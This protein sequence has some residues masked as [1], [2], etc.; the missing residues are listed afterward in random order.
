M[1]GSGTRRG[2][3]L[4]GVG[5]GDATRFCVTTINRKKRVFF[6]RKYASSTAPDSVT[7]ISLK[8]RVVTITL[9]KRLCSH[10]L[11]SLSNAR[12]HTVIDIMN[13]LSNELPS[14]WNWQFICLS[15]PFRP[16]ANELPASSPHP[17]PHLQ[18]GNSITSSLAIHNISHR[19]YK[20]LAMR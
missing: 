11:D 1:S 5:V 12:E 15:S 8:K 19:N 4:V 10:R 16:P 13:C 9:K 17:R 2:Q 18:E 20:R 3:G 14:G 7:T 6:R